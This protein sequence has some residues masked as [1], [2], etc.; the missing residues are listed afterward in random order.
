MGAGV[1][2]TLSCFG[3]LSQAEDWP[4]YRGSARTDVSSETNLL[5]QWPTAGPTLVWTAKGAGRGYSSP[6]VANGKVFTVGDSSTA[7]PDKDEYLTCFDE[8]TGALLW[9]AKTGPAWSEHRQESWNGSRGTPTVGGGNVYAINPHGLLV[10]VQISDGSIKWKKDLKAD[11]GGKK[12]DQ[13]GYGESPL[14]DGDKVIVT[15]GGEQATMVA[16]NAQTG[17]TIWSCPRPGDVGA[18]HSSVVISEIGGQKVYV[19]NSGG[20]PMGV[21]ADTGK[22]L[23]VY[24]VEPPTAF[25]PSP[26]IKDDLVFSVAGYSLGGALL[27]QVAGANGAVSIEEVY[28]VNPRLKNKHG[29]VLRIGDNLFAGQQDRNRV[30]CI[31]LMTGDVKWNQQGSGQG[32][33]SLVAA[34][35]KLFLHYQNGVVALAKADPSGFSETSSF[36][37]P[38]QHGRNTPAWAHPSIANGKLLIREG[39]NILCYDISK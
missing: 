25:I 10:C 36:T 6:I 27:K 11:F 12:K 28:G 39:D 21:A 29:G 31:D 13:W 24:D 9:S 23:W 26:I 8:K 18:G 3:Q 38:G 14:F 30:I 7:T 2:L 33:I 1:A 22:L 34:D 15:P 35:G 16:L 19:Q 20:G 32:S 17:A 5:D 4:T 37:T